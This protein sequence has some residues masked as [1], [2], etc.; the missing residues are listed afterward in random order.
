MNVRK[1]AVRLRNDNGALT[2]ETAATDAAAAVRVVLAAEGA[3]ARSIAWV[4]EQP[5]CEYC[6]QPA[7]RRVRESGEFVCAKCARAQTDGPVR[8]YVLPLAVTRWPRVSERTAP[9]V[10]SADG[11]LYI[12]APEHVQR[13]MRRRFEDNGITA[14][15][16]ERPDYFRHNVGN[17]WDGPYSVRDN[18]DGSCTYRNPYN[19]NEDRFDEHGSWW[20]DG[21]HHPWSDGE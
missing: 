20:S 14:I 17:W 4:A 6:D 5:V 15:D 2:I 7:T 9:T 8:E 3:P 11:Y 21:E 13:A 18:G 1:Y 12:P 16:L 19:G 10:D